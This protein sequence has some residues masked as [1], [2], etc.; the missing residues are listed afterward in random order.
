MSVG[1]ARTAAVCC[2]IG[3]CGRGRLFHFGGIVLEDMAVATE[4][5]RGGN[6][7]CTFKRLCFPLASGSMPSNTRDR[8]GSNV[9]TSIIIII[10]RAFL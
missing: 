9:S 2:G 3:R 4:L 7:M 8:R 10:I 1:A 5:H 6:V